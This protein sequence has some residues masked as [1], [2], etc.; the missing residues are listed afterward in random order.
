MKGKIKNAGRTSGPAFRA[1]GSLSRQS[2]PREL[3]GEDDGV[4]T[5]KLFP[6]RTKRPRLKRAVNFAGCC[7]LFIT[8][9]PG[10]RVRL[11]RK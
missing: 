10:D 8:C 6:L 11:F 2:S 3:I 9:V 1:R 5:L 7:F 4:M